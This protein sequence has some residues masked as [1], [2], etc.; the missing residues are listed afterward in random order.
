[1][2]ASGNRLWP[3]LLLIGTPAA[4]QEPRVEVIRGSE[5]VRVSW[6][7]SGE[8]REET[9]REDPTPKPPPRETHPPAAR[10]ADD[11][12][13]TIQIFVEAADASFPAGYVV[14][15]PRVDHPRRSY[16]RTDRHR[17][18]RRGSGLVPRPWQRGHDQ[19]L[20]ARPAPGFIPVRK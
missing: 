1:M 8:R 9:L 18:S 2:S 6:N 10:A 7:E 11:S 4:A 3:L 5:I 13:P 16:V 15:W 14:V 12:D 20:R 19:A 17:W